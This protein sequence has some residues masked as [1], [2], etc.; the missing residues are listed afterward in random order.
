MQALNLQSGPLHN[1][2]MKVNKESIVSRMISSQLQQRTNKMALLTKV[3]GV[4]ELKIL[5]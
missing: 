3:D 1:K 4:I 2:N 5:I